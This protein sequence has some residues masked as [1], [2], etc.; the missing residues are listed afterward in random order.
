M[1]LLLEWAQD[2]NW[3]GAL[4]IYHRITQIPYSSIEFAFKHTRA[5]AEQ[6]DDSCWLAVLDDLYK[7]MVN[8]QDA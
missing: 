5:K 7:D 8:K 6:A 1:F 2:L 4:I 3:P